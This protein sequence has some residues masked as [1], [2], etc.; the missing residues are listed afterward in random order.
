[1]LELIRVYSSLFISDLTI[2]EQFESKF[3]LKV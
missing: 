3:P 2:G 1:M